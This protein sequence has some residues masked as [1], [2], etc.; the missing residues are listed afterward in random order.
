MKLLVT[1]SQGMVGK[2]FCKAAKARGH[3]VLGIDKKGGL[4]LNDPRLIPA[5]AKQMPDFQMI[6]HL[7]ATCSTSNSLINP[8]QDFA[9]NVCGTF[10]VAELA[11]VAKKPVIYTSTCKVEPDGE[12]MRTPYGLTKYMGEELL[13]EYRHSFG[14]PFVINRPGT[15]YGPGQSASPESGWLSW[16]I[17]AAVEK[18]PITIFGIG[19]QVRDVLYVDDYVELLLDQVDNF[20]KYEGKV[21]PV[22]GGAANA[23][24]LL[25]T[26]EY[27]DYKNYNFGKPRKGDIKEVVCNNIE[28][29][30]ING[31]KPKMDWKEGIKLVKLVL[32]VENTRTQA[33]VVPVEGSE[34]EKTTDTTFEVKKE[35]TQ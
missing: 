8:A 19:D 12:G 23:I 5:I 26:L 25:Q 11:R 34:N 35:E 14:I 17:K 30:D 27:L 21:F 20:E 16:F 6:V 3:V 31:W 13:Q 32:S 4:N 18:E 33:P 28:V 2:A 15:L 1:G 24:S 22:G 10:K 7:A 29:S 9:D